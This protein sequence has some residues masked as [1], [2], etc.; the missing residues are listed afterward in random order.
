MQ[1]QAP[2]L[3]LQWDKDGEYLAILQEGNGVV[4]LWSLSN[5]RV[6]PLET[7]L[8]DPTFLS[9]SKTGPQLA[10]GTAKGSLL[11]YNKT[12]KQK[13]PVVGK[14]SKMITCGSWSKTGNKLVLG[15]DDR[16]LTIS[17]ENGDTLL[18]TEIKHVPLET[19]F[20]YNKSS[21][22][23]KGTNDDNVVS[24]NLNGKSLLLYNIMDDK[25]D[26]MELTFA[27][28][29][30]GRGCKYG[31]VVSHH[32]FEEGL[33]LVGFSG[34]Y[35][36]SVSTNAHDLGE[37]KYARRFHPHNLSSF[38]YNPQLQRAA[39]AG[40]DGVRVI[41]TRDFTESKGDFIATEDLENGR[42]SSLAWSPDGQILTIGTA[43]GNV[44]NFLAKMAVLYASYRTS[45]AYLSSLREVA[46]VDTVRRGRPIDVT[47]KL[48]PSLLALG[49][50][51]VAA[52]MNNRVYYHRLSDT[53][54]D[55]QPINEQEYVGVVKEVQMNG[56]FAAILT[57][58]KAM[59]HPIENSPTAQ[60][61]TRTF[62]SREEGSFA[63]VTC[64]ALTDDFLYYGTEAG[65]VEVFFLSEWTL[66]SGAELRLD[67]PIKRLYPNSSGTRVVVVD[68]A[69]QCFLFNPVTGG[70]VNQSI[71]HFEQ[72]PTNVV[73]VM[74]D[75]EEKNVIMFYDGKYIHSFIY[76]PVSIKGSMVIKLGPVVVSSGGEVNLTPDKIEL[77]PGN[78]PILSNAGALTCQTVAGSPSSIVHPFFRDIAETSNP[79]GANGSSRNRNG[80]GDGRKDKKFL[81]NKFCQ[82][83]A[84][85][86]LS[87]AWEV[88][89]ELDK[90]QFWLA[91]SGKAME[92]MNVE[93]ACRVYRQLGDA[94][95]VMAL[96]DCLN[97]E[98]KNLLAGQISLLF[99]DYQRAQELFLASS[100][101]SAALD[102][103]RDL[104]QWDQALA[105]AQ[106]LS[107]PQ[108]P[109]ICIQ[110]G[111]QLEFRDD[112][113]GALRMFE[114]A[115]SAHDSEGHNLCPEH[116]VSL[117]MMGIA[118]CNLRQ[119]NI[120]RGIRLANEL[121]DKQLFVDCGGILEGQKQY[122][123]AASMYLKGLQYEKAALIYTKYLIKN[124]A[125]RISEAAVIMQK[126]D[127][128]NLNS[129]FAK[130]CVAAKRYEDALRAFER[131][132][133]VDKVRGSSRCL[134]LMRLL[135]RCC[136]CSATM[137]TFPFL[138]RG[139]QQR[140]NL[141]SDTHTTFFCT[142]GGAEAAFPRPSAASL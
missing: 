65:T 55:A 27:A 102:M 18:H 139:H 38:A 34:G 32:W 85:L 44:Y 42:V 81:V 113:A 94:G 49:S 7:N 95:M 9:W 114:D 51:H 101:P 118:R 138:I 117:A 83:L 68:S 107:A 54:Q 58:S 123:E 134:L 96:Q 124:D 3:S 19:H 31:D 14:H 88:A 140:C 78:I 133:D 84:L 131:A 104:L 111:Q 26:P 77:N 115:I 6:V 129:A 50:N 46:V 80:E 16:T 92:L 76:V 33:L 45:V 73:S 125:G 97:I 90:R 23:L 132:K 105:L 103:R 56:T 70:G 86:K 137:R 75:H 67:N 99:C 112:S 30:N 15:S 106:V 135:C 100:R 122:S 52:G 98:D 24:A 61:Q 28:G 119:G 37:E 5:R 25:E 12:R 79:R 121:D 142:G 43:S 64:I 89:L 116:L 110:Y 11:I 21:A 2:I 126:V 1:T 39:T 57:D 108:V 41:D 35:L 13:I 10:I 17:N 127:N 62:P 130:A 22:A 36:L 120:P 91:L 141:F 66:L 48:E 20:T 29:D 82:A 63:K 87:A 109:E 59:L 72:A 8:R 71:T 60:S 47:V 4:P 74:W 136:C 40:D 69:N 93:L 53:H 128:D